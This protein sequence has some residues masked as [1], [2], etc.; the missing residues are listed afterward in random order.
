MAAVELQALL[1]FLSQDAKVPLATALS[2]VKELQQANLAT[3]EKLAKVKATEITTMFPDGKMAKVIIAAAKRVTKKRAAGDDTGPSPKKRKKDSRVSD[4]APISPADLE[5]SVGLPTSTASEAEL[6]T[7]TIFSNRA[8]LFL[9]FTVTLLKH[10]MPEQPLTSRLSLAQAF[11]STSSR[12]RAVNLGI[13]TLDRADVEA[14]ER[15]AMGQP[16]VTILGKEIKILRRWGYEWKE[17][18]ETGREGVEGSVLDGDQKAGAKLLDTG[19]GNVDGGGQTAAEEQPAL[20]ALDLEALRKSNKSD[21]TLANAKAGNNSSLPI[22]TPQSARAYLLKSFDTPSDGKT[23]KTSAGA[24]AAVKE[25]NLGC[26]L[27]AL[28]LLYESWAAALSPAE[29][30]KRTWGWYVKVRPEVEQGVAGWGGKNEIRLADILAL[31]RQ[32]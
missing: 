1:R 24:R 18:G 12:S 8:P 23:S 22:Y 6:A 30:D 13:Q 16:S 2:K 26:L 20:W 32:P 7:M 3:P 31:R 11:I 29:L 10:T 25:Q 19:D 5:A 14:E 21:I 27:Q 15:L 4:D 28:D 9:A 17:S